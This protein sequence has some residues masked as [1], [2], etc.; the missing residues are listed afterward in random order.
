[1]GKKSKDKGGRGE[2]AAAKCFR[3]WWGTDFTRTPASGGFAT[4]KF[5]DD[6]NAAGDLVTPDPTFPFCVECKWV[7]DWTLEQVL[8][9]DGC[10]IFQWWQQARAECPPNKLPLLVFKRNNHPFYCLVESDD[11]PNTHYLRD[12]RYY[13]V[14]LSEDITGTYPM[15]VCIM[16]LSDFFKLDPESWRAAKNRLVKARQVRLSYPQN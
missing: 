5:R 6:W 2:R 15:E 11:L 8:R 3:D 16:T 9:N 14:T 7:E 1:M 13:T 12:V 4:Q 10:L